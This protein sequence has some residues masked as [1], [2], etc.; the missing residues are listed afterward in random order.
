MPHEYTGDVATG[1]LIGSKML[2][3][4]E[5]LETSYPTSVRQR[6]QRFS[7]LIPRVNTEPL[8]GDVDYTFYESAGHKFPS[9]ATKTSSGVSRKRTAS[10]SALRDAVRRA[11]LSA[12]NQAERMETFASAK[13][14]IDLSL[15]GFN[16]LASLQDLWQ[17]RRGRE[18]V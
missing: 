11:L 8:T 2:Q 4:A 14:L 12:Q 9:A 1:N 3:A 7:P 10:A 17:L 5:E 6:L 16:L 13:E 18:R 15:A